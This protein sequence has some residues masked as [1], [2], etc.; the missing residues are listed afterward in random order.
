[1]PDK[2]EDDAD[3]EKRM[4]SMG[5]VFRPVATF[6]SSGSEASDAISS[7]DFSP[8]GSHFATG[9]LAR[10][11]RL[12]SFTGNQPAGDMASGSRKRTC[13][14]ES[15]AGLQKLDE[16]YTPAKLSSLAWCPSDRSVISCGDYDGVV[17]DWDAECGVA[18][19]ERYDHG[20]R[21]VWSVDYS[22]AEH[23][24]GLCASASAD[25][26]VR[27]WTARTDTSVAVMRPSSAGASVCSAQF[28]PFR[29]NLLTAASA[30]GSFSL[31][32]IR[33]TEECVT[34]SRG[35]ARAVSYVRFVDEARV[36]SASIDNSVKVW[37]ME[38]RLERKW[39][40]QH[41]NVKN[42]V[43]LSV[44]ESRGGLIACGSETNQVFVYHRG[45][46]KSLWRS[47]R[48]PSADDD[49]G[50][51]VGAVCWRRVDGGHCDDVHSLLAANSDG[52]LHLIHA[53]VLG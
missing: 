9:G 38:L 28:S 8:D 12:Y 44:L 22:R 11:I 18:V 13:P 29:P 7:I 52:S 2:E 34:S 27:L 24:P 41:L 32:D 6:T 10:K 17:T 15:A 45:D 30:D 26:T 33:N 1:M 42:F 36:V 47:A 19:V 40:G 3:K 25:G 39:E 46:E 43:G 35:H 53:R 50:A 14:A 31:F 16:I 49:A 51:F 20:G 48:L 37:D 4:G 21:R 5:L 23:H